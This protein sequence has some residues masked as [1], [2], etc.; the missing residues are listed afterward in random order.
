MPIPETF[1]LLSVAQDA[2]SQAGEILRAE[3]RDPQRLPDKGFRDWV[4]ETDYRAQ[5]QITRVI[6]KQ[7]PG[8]GFLTEEADDT[9]S[10]TG[11]VVWVVDPVDGTSN[12]SRQQPNFCIS[13]AAVADG[14]VQV[15]VIYDPIRQEMFSAAAGRETTLDGQPLQ[16]STV[17]ELANAVIGLDWAHE[18]RKRQ[19]SLDALAAVAHQVHTIRALGSAALA[20]AWV[21]AGRLDAYFNVGLKPWDVAAAALLIRQAGGRLSDWQ[22]R[23]WSPA[24][25][26]EA[27]VASNG[28]IHSALLTSLPALP[29]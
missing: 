29:S 9:L 28:R 7:F 6:G 8:H 22:D 15:G 16:A 26:H 19:H 21:A 23:P 25:A 5:R 14:A 20:L 13:L 2:A 3:W 10:S 27:C 1:A 4:T 11:P 24:E 12:F 18:Q 17:S